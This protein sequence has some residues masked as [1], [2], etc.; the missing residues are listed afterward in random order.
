MDQPKYWAFI[1]YSHRDT[2]WADWLHK[3]LESYRPP[4]RLIEDRARSGTQASDAGG[5]R[6]RSGSVSSGVT[7]IKAVTGQ[8]SEV[9]R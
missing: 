2:Q 6:L 4:K 7:T 9:I 8:G 1:S 3:A 5:K